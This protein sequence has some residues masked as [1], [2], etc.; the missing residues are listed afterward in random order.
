MPLDEAK[1]DATGKVALVTGA[2]SGIGLACAR[3]LVSEG[4]KVAILDIQ[5]DA[6]QQSADQI[7]AT[8]IHGDASSSSDVGNAFR[9][10]QDELGGLDIV[11]LNAGIYKGEF[12]IDDLADDEYRRIVGVNVDGVVFGVREAS[13]AMAGKGG[14]ILATASLSG[15][16]PYRLNPLY[17]LTKHAVVGLVRSLAPTLAE[18]Q[19]TLNCLCPPVVDTQMADPYREQLGGGLDD[20]LIS[21]DD[22]AEAMMRVFASSKTGE[23]WFVGRRG[24]T[25][26]IRFRSLSVG[27]GLAG[28]REV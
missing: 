19:I 24:D 6:G 23:A 7:G 12:D 3:R 20:M 18:R 1:F 28:A 26:P 22:V 2:A 16:Y 17:S 10:V 8:F 25:R 11:H 27:M 21:A 4:A 9:R 13:K 5:Q 15:V 14:H